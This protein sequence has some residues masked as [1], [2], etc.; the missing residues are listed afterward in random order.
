LLTPVPAAPAAHPAPP[1][2]A[3][4]LYAAGFFTIPLLRAFVLSQRNAE[5]DARN[6]GRLEAVDLLQSQDPDVVAKSEA[7]RKLG[8]RKVIGATDVVYTTERSTGDQVEEME[9]DEFDRKLGVQPARRRGG[10]PSDQPRQLSDSS[11]AG[12]RIDDVFGRMQQQQQRERE[13]QFERRRQ[14][15]GSSRR[16]R[17]RQ[18]NVDWEESA[19]RGSGSGSR[20]RD[21]DWDRLDRW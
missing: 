8:G 6:S 16:E 5:V 10:S 18:I 14:Q 17:Q 9:A 21:S 20:R 12:R 3:L 11:S 15:G 19:S 13:L 1:S 7:A 4:Q 2:P